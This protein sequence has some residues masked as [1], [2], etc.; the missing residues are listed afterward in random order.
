MFSLGFVIKTS[1][2]NALDG[3][4]KQI[5]DAIDLL[6]PIRND[7]KMLR[8]LDKLDKLELLEQLKKLDSLDVLTKSWLLNSKFLS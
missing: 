4:L 1:I 7:L 3:K 5:K 2:E 8:K 6:Q